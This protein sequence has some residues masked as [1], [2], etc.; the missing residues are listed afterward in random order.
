[1]VNSENSDD[2]F[3]IVLLQRKINYNFA[4]QNL[5]IRALTRHAYAK[6]NSLADYD[7]MDAYA[8]L[9]DSVIDVVV[10]LRLM[11]LG[12][13]EKGIITTK[14]TDLVNMT[15]LRNLAESLG[16]EN[17]VIWGKGEKQQHIWT[18]GRV[19]AECMEAVT[20]AVYLDGGINA[21]KEF[22]T[23][24]GFFCKKNL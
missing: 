2:N 20:G 21:V 13:H 19:L 1:M 3:S 5:L 8:T 7:Y 10:I 11:E 23:Y 24:V 16:L 17:Y 18:S 9:G 6:E 4:D 12:D 14:K 15:R 22:L